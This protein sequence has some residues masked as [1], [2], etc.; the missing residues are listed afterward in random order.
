MALNSCI[1]FEFSDVIILGGPITTNA[2]E[3]ESVRSIISGRVIS[4]WTESDWV[5]GLLCHDNVSGTHRINWRD[6]D[7]R[8]LVNLRLTG[9]I[10]GHSDYQRKMTS[11]LRLIDACQDDYKINKFYSSSTSS[12]SLGERKI[13]YRLKRSKSL[14][15]IPKKRKNNPRIQ[16]AYSVQN[17]IN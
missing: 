8:R 2:D 14:S 9:S 17:L 16:K 10:S 12:S 5:L 1:V 4:G 3:W 15:D 11:I 13:I 7:D 6:Q